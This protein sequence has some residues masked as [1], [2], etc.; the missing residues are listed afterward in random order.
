MRLQIHLVN[1]SAV[2]VGIFS[3]ALAL[4]SFHYISYDICIC[5]IVIYDF[6]LHNVK[7]WKENYRC[8]A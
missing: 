4:T 5:T 7:V 1:C 6:V 2:A 8:H 3:F